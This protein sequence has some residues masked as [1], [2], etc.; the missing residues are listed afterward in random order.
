[1]QDT[2]KAARAPI[3]EGLGYGIVSYLAI[4]QTSP[5]YLMIASWIGF[6]VYLIARFRNEAGAKPKTI[7][8]GIASVGRAIGW[9]LIIG[10]ALIS[11]IG[12]SQD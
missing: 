10:L 2:K 3:A 12:A 8:V 1:M 7:W 11:C 9:T 6:L 5:N 4:D